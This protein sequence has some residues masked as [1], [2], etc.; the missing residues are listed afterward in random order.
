RA[1]WTVLGFVGVATIV[2]VIALVTHDF[3]VKYVADVGSKETP[4]YYTV[5]ALWGALE[6]SILFWAFLLSLYTVAFLWT[7]RARFPTIQA[8]A[9]GILLAIST[10]FLFLIAGPG[11]P[12]ARMNPAPADGAGPNVLLQNNWM[13]GVHP[14]LLYL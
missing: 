3:S 2:M 8:Y 5:I 12:F 13:M 11:D 6:G 1:A 9:G 7:T 14:P 4:L 10:F